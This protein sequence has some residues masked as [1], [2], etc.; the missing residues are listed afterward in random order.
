MPARSLLVRASYLVLCAGMLLV[1]LA[2]PAAAHGRGSDATNYRSQ[3]TS[4]PDVPGVSW[5]V[6]GSDEFLSVTNASDVE[7]TVLGYEGEPYLRV[8]PE[9]VFENRASAATYQNTDR[10]ANVGEL[11]EDVGANV[12]PRWQQ[13]SG[14]NSYL[15]HDHRAHWM[16]QNL[17][18]SVTDPSVETVVQQ[19]EVPFTIDGRE[20]IVEGELRWIPAP[21]AGVWVAL[22]LLLTVPALLGL[23]S[24]RSALDDS[25]DA[26]WITALARPAAVVLGV[27]ALLNL[28]HLVDDL[29]AVPL[30][31]PTKALAA[32]QTALF[33]GI[34][35]FGALRGWQGRDGAFTAL[36]V[37]AGAILIGQGVL[38]LSVLTTSQA[39]TLFPE[40]AARLVVALSIVQALPVGAV[41][42]IGNRRLAA[43][44]PTV[45][46]EAAATT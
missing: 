9:G 44:A 3:V 12:E 6:Y 20:R 17:P 45:R 30:P 19:W 24:L 15:W 4:E 38:Y 25:P 39:A 31:G 28:T 33:I 21:S 42:V 11:P 29:F 1:V 13:V 26:P 5:Q 36:G 18:P 16:S 46:S 43:A 27:V 7:L 40:F 2:G 32:A 8:G 41:A 22:A 23:R 35:A 34:G 14:A 37:G 10:Y